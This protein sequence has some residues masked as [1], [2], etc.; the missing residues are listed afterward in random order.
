MDTPAD[1]TMDSAWAASFGIFALLGGW[2]LW[3]IRN[4]PES[5]A[6]QGGESFWS[7]FRSS[8]D[9]TSRPLLVLMAIVFLT[10]SAYQAVSP[11]VLI[12]L[13]ER[14][15]AS[16]MELAWAYLPMALIW[17]LLPSRMGIIGDRVGR[18]LPITIGL[19]VSGTM[20]LLL[21][22]APS[23]I[24]LAILLAVEALAFTA[25]I[26]AEEALVADLSGSQQR[27][28]A[29]GLFTF[30]SG[31]GAVLGPLI[32]GWLYDHTTHTVPFY[33]MATL[34]FIGALLI[35]L[36]VQEPERPAASV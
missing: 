6:P 35:V 22:H 20:A 14:F 12:F 27:G 4:L 9:R 23:L 16:L 25:S 1:Q 36:L 19:V 15:G 2:A 24:V 18:K 17:A 32:G 21:P 28:E 10:A 7:S 33:Y 29:F 3:Q 31:L 8:W 13:Q 26:P 30:A 11:L 5:R 34:V